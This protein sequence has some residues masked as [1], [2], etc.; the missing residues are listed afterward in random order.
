MNR[1]SA[2]FFQTPIR[3]RV[4]IPVS[5]FVA[6]VLLAM[7]A[8]AHAQD[9]VGRIAFAKGIA[10]AQ[11]EGQA[12]RFV[13]R[14]SPVL[15]GDVITTGDRSFAVVRLNDDSKFTL[16]PNSVF[17]LENYSEQKQSAV[18]RLFKGGFR[19]V[20]GFIAKLRPQQYRVRT[21]V[22]TIGIRGTK[23]DARLCAGGDCD[24]P[25][26]S[27]PR[28]KA[29]AD[30]PV[31]GRAA[32]VVGRLT[33]KG[34]DAETRV[35]RSGGPIYEGDLLATGTTGHAV[36]AFRDETRMTLRR[37]SRFQVEEYTPKPLKSSRERVFFRLLRGGLRV[38]TGLIG[39]SSPRSFKVATAVA[40]IGIRGTG[41]DL[42]CEGACASE[43]QTMPFSPAAALQDC[44][45]ASG[46]PAPASQQGSVVAELA[47]CRYAVET[48]QSVLIKPDDAHPIRL[49][50]KPAFMVDDAPRPDEVIVD[51]ENYF[52]VEAEEGK[53]GLFVS[54]REGHVVLSND[55]G[56]IDLGAGESGFVDSGS[57]EISRLGQVPGFMGFDPIPAPEDVDPVLMGLLNFFGEGIDRSADEPMACTIQ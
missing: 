42:N 38:F 28:T 51:F 23:F 24:S 44:S 13:G 45:P 33:A 11:V 36:I 57:G 2:Q 54:V 6:F 47:D 12:P 46:A 32:L 35:L 22:A 55:T 5:A 34:A 21:P 25:A 1:I 31:V 3:C 49:A 52:G 30:S 7:G 14:G 20:T 16:R 27:K 50:G 39:R 4:P 8:T 53:P 10:T 41:F 17:A 29:V 48:Q 26:V 37:N 40:T 56:Q 19:A 43:G 15:E 18:L 9:Q